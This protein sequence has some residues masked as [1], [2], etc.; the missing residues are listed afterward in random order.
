M[1][2]QKSGVCLLERL[3]MILAQRREESDREESEQKSGESFCSQRLDV[4]QQAMP[5]K[6]QSHPQSAQGVASG[7]AVGIIKLKLRVVRPG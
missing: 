2:L 1:S 6:A 3:K 5:L 7:M 4:Q